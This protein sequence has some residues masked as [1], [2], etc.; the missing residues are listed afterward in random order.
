VSTPDISDGY[1]PAWYSCG[2]RP[3]RRTWGEAFCEQQ[4]QSRLQV[5]RA[6]ISRG[7]RKGRDWP[8][9]TSALRGGL[10]TNDLPEER[11]ACDR[12]R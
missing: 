11:L 5:C 4:Q 10:V 9:T 6:L 2:Q 3:Q 8:A 12:T 7:S 1:V